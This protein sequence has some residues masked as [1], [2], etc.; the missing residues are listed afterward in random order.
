M[1]KVYPQIKKQA[2]ATLYLQRAWIAPLPKSLINLNNTSEKLRVNITVQNVGHEPA[3]KLRSSGLKSYFHTPGVSIEELPSISDW[4]TYDEN[5]IRE[6]CLKTMHEQKFKKPLSIVYPS[7][8]L[9]PDIQVGNDNDPGTPPPGKDRELLKSED[10]ILMLRGCLV[11]ET[12]GQIAASAYC[13]LLIPDKT[14]DISQWGFGA[15]PVG[16]TDLVLGPEA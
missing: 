10:D 4:D 11:Y 7:H 9:A 6:M 12:V 2:D 3:R 14:K 1:Q 15:C 5:A 16:N 8:A 13:Y